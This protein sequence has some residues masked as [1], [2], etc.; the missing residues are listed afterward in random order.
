MKKIFL[1]IAFFAL[2]FPAYAARENY[3]VLFDCTASMKGKD[4][5]CPDIWEE[6]KDILVDA[7]YSING[8]DARVVVIPFQDKVG[9][10]MSFNAADQGKSAVI[11]QIIAYVDTMIG[12]RHSGTSICR[13][14]DEGLKYLEE[15]CFNF[16]MLLTDGA[17]NIDLKTGRAAVFKNGKPKTTS[18]AEI[19]DNCIEEVCKRIRKWCD[20]GPN[21]IM[22]YSTLTQG[23]RV[24]KIIETAKD[25]SNIEFVP[26]LNIALLNER[27]VTLN[28]SDFKSSSE[29]RVALRLSNSLS[30]KATVVSSNSAFDLTLDKGGFVN[31]KATLVIRPKKGY[32]ELRDEIGHSAEFKVTI[33]SED[34]SELNILLNELTV[35]VLGSPERVLSVGYERTD[36][37][38]ASHYRKFL[39]KKSSVPD[40]LYVKLSFSFNEY[41]KSADSKVKFDIRAD[42]ADCCDFF[43]D[44]QES[45]SFTVNEDSEVEVGVVFRPDAP[46]GI[47]GFE[48]FSSEADVDRIDNAR[49][50]DGETWKI[51]MRAKYNIRTNPLKIALIAMLLLLLGLLLLWIAVLRYVFYPRIKI[52]LVSVGKEDQALI[53]RRAKGFI[54]FVI[55]SSNKRQGALRDLF[56]GKVQYLKMDEA[57]GVTDDIVIEPFDK[58]SVRIC[59]KPQGPYMITLNRLKIKK[60]GQPSEISEVINQQSKK[61]IRI[62]IQ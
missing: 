1:L 41:A 13:A 38:K 40:T 30:G 3:I 48:I 51:A 14:W 59:K 22:S 36:V 4:E 26:G 27:T 32:Q 25:C 35:T 29:K 9:K 33:E 20:F 7:L 49:I 24:E 58:R 46:Q 17:D 52:S 2:S 50:E 37:G 12:T 34:E 57:D 21:K 6:A 8:D 16:M 43:V 42:R 15:D 28:V 45:A 11:D 18:D 55:T 23:A 54:K 31:G 19:L 10:V 56:T 5:G 62:Q 61:K 47:C 44:G 60:V 39:W 53:P